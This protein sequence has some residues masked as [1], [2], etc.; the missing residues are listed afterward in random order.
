MGVEWGEG[1]GGVGVEWGEGG[2][3]VRVRVGW[4]GG[5]GGGGVGQLGQG[6]YIPQHGNLLG[7]P[8]DRHSGET[9]GKQT[10]TLS[11]HAPSNV[12]AM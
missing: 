1:G 9:C 4:G 6:L 11:A 10:V 12:T 5:E 8:L 2:G 7:S 3:G